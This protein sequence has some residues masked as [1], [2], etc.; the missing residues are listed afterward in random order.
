MSWPGLPDAPAHARSL[1]KLPLTAPPE[2]LGR[3]FDSPLVAFGVWCD[4]AQSAADTI[5]GMRNLRPQPPSAFRPGLDG[6]PAY[7]VVSMLR[8]PDGQK[9]LLTYLRYG[10]DV[11]AAN[12]LASWKTPIC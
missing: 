1:S 11:L 6:V 10:V 9:G 8:H 5:C 3:N 4:A 12:S 7:A 2:E